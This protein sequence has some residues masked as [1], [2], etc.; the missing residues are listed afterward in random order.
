M[1]TGSL[2]D[3]DITAALWQISANEVKTWQHSLVVYDWDIHLVCGKLESLDSLLTTSIQEQYELR[4][5]SGQATQCSG[6]TLLS[7]HP[8]GCFASFKCGILS[9]K[10][11]FNLLESMPICLQEHEGSAICVT[12][13]DIRS[14]E[15]VSVICALLC[16]NTQPSPESHIQVYLR[17]PVRSKARDFIIWG[18]LHEKDCCNTKS[19]PN[20]FQVCPRRISHGLPYAYMF[21]S[22]HC[23]VEASNNAEAVSV[24]T[25]QP[26]VSVKI[27]CQLSSNR[28]HQMN[29]HDWRTQLKNQVVFHVCGRC[30]V[31]A[32]DEL[33]FRCPGRRLQD[34][35][36]T[37]EFCERCNTAL[38]RCEVNAGF[39]ICFKCKG[40]YINPR[41]LSVNAK[42]VTQ[43]ALDLVVYHELSN[44]LC[45]IAVPSQ[46]VDHV[47]NTGN[48]IELL[49]KEIHKVLSAARY[50]VNDLYK[51]LSDDVASTS[52]L[53]SLI[54][55]AGDTFLLEHGHLLEPV[56]QSLPQIEVKYRLLEAPVTH[57]F[58]SE[59]A[60]V[61]DLKYKIFPDLEPSMLSAICVL[62]DGNPIADT[63]Q[64]SSFNYN[65]IEVA[66]EIG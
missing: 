57:I 35:P 22:D 44:L 38:L 50:G 51:L 3:L 49:F 7:A 48:L 11:K 45:T 1:V 2:S 23:S 6:F 46:P 14:G 18:G 47:L 16:S 8:E 4:E 42:G 60:S 28:N 52:T 61:Q 25:M 65:P 30:G 63:V 27:L 54:R 12:L 31:V 40:L 64:L 59:R 21:C 55:S 29:T 34:L 39:D 53:K 17:Q 33:D 26:Y 5:M 15:H 66:I 10:N 58:L 62:L 20:R 19:A 24:K 9:K 36:K 56:L 13:E 32:S 43:L 41:E 37:G